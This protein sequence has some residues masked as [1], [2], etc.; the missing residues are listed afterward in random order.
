MGCGHKHTIITQQL[1]KERSFLG[2]YFLPRNQSQSM[3]FVHVSDAVSS[4]LAALLIQSETEAS[5]FALMPSCSD[6]L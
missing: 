2:K 5:G 3:V 6:D 4:H 1:S